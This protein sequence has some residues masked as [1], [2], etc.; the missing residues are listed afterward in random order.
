MYEKQNMEISERLKTMNNELDN[1]K[2]Q[3][4]KA[5]SKHSDQKIQKERI[6]LQINSQDSKKRQLGKKKKRSD[7][8]RIIYESN[9]SFFIFYEFIFQKK[10]IVALQERQ[11]S[12]IEAPEDPQEKQRYQ[13]KLKLITNKRVENA[14]K[15]KN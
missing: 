12:E 6:Q 1:L 5:Q 8:L 3:Q 11:L 14:I 4:S 9:N 2:K 15:T 10:K 13:Q 7:Y